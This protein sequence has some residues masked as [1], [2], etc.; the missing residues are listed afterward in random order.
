MKAINFPGTSLPHPAEPL[1]LIGLDRR[2]RM[3]STEDGK[4]GRARGAEDDWTEDMGQ[5]F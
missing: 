3:E 5:A 1:G 2:A 4:A